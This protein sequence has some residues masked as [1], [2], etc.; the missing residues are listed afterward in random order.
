MSDTNESRVP[1][2]WMETT[3][4]QMKAVLTG[5]QPI[6]E[7][8]VCL[9]LLSAAEGFLNELGRSGIRLDADFP[10][11][12]WQEVKD[13]IDDYLYPEDIDAPRPY[14][15]LDAMRGIDRG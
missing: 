5:G 7:W 14:E 4:E 2:L 8:Q 12:R 9:R 15:R 10:D 1:D 13:L 11:A 3:R 6:A